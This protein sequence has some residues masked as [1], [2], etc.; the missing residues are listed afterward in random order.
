MPLT[1]TYGDLNAISMLSGSSWDEKNFAQQAV[2]TVSAAAIDMGVSMWNSVANIA[3]FGEYEDVST[4][5]ILQDMGADGALSAYDNNKDAVEL[6]SFVGGVFVPGMAAVKISRGIRAGLKGTNFLSAARHK[7]DLLKFET[8]VKDAQTATDEYRNLRKTMFLRGQAENLMDNVAAE[9]AIL[10]TFNAHP[11]ME[12]YLADPVSNFGISMAIGG[13]LGG[14]IS[15]LITRSELNTLGGKVESAAL[16]TVAKKAQLYNV[17]FSDTSSAII[18]MD[19]AAKNLDNL[20][21]MANTTGLEKEMAM[22]V[23]DSLRNRVTET[24]KAN[25]DID[26]YKIEDA[27]VRDQILANYKDSRM[28]GAER[29]DF[30]VYKA[31]K[32]QTSTAFSK[33]KNAIFKTEEIDIGTG[34]TTQT[35]IKKAF[36]NPELNTF[37]SEKDAL[38]MANAADRTDIKG[39]QALAN[40][41]AVRQQTSAWKDI[42]ISGDAGAAEMD[43]GAKLLFYKGQSTADLLKAEILAEDVS[44]INGYVGAVQERLAALKGEL[45]ELDAADFDDFGKYTKLNAALNNEIM[46]LS[47]AKVKLYSGNRVQLVELE[48][49]QGL[50]T[51]TTDPASYIK[52]TYFEDVTQSIRSGEIRPLVRDDWKGSYGSQLDHAQQLSEGFYT[53]IAT[54]VGRPATRDL[55]NHISPAKL[56]SLTSE[57]VAYPEVKKLLTSMTD[58]DAGLSD[59]TKLLLARWIGGS[60]QDKELFRNA[61]T[62]AR[63]MRRGLDSTTIYHKELTEI[64]NSPV[65]KQA[66]E[67]MKRHA[68]ASGNMYL[69]RGVKGEINGDAPVSSYSHI[70]RSARAFSDSDEVGMYKVNVEDVVGYL[71]S[72]EKEWLVGTGKR[73]MQ[74]VHYAEGGAEHVKK[75]FGNAPAATSGIPKGF[76][77]APTFE[78]L[79][80]DKLTTRLATEQSKNYINAVKAGTPKEIAA[81]QYNIP[82]E[83]MDVMADPNTAMDYLSQA[84]D[85]GLTKF[86]KWAAPSQVPDMLSPTRKQLVFSAT[87]QKHMGIL[88]D[89]ADNHRKAILGQMELKAE[90]KALLNEM[91]NNEASAR[92]EAKVNM[93]DEQFAAI[94]KNWVETAIL[95]SQSQLARSIY[96]SVLNAKDI[97][98]LRESLKE[99]VNGKGGNPLY[100]SA[101]FVTSRMG[102]VGKLVTDISDKR[103]R[104]TNQLFE[105]LAVPIT[106]QLKKLTTNEVA[107][108]EFA[109]FDNLRQSSKDF[110]RYDPDLRTYVTTPKGAKFD[111]TTNQFVVMETDAAGNTV[112]R[113]VAGEPISEL[114][115]ADESVHMAMQRLQDA[116][117]EIYHMQVTSNRVAGMAPPN[118]IGFW[119]P[120]TSLVNKHVGYVVNLDT[121]TIK[122]LIGNTEEELKGLKH[123]YAADKKVN[124]VFY[125]RQDLASAKLQNFDQDTL[126]R[127]TAADVSKQKKGIGLVVPD[128]DPQR[129]SDIIQGIQNRMNYQASKL[130][131]DS[132]FDV[133]SKLDMVS[134]YNR[135]ALDNQGKQGFQSAVKQMANKDTSKDIKA[136]LLGHSQIGGHEAMGYVNKAAS[137]A[138]HYGITA[139]AKAWNLVAP[140]L[141][142]GKVDYKKYV[143]SL[144]AQNIPN[145]YEVF[146]EAARAPM[147]ERA[148]LSIGNLNPDRVINA[149]NA[150]AATMALKFGELAQ[151]LVNM[152]SL[153]ILM[154][155]TISRSVKAAEIET[156][157]Q[158]FEGNPLAVM[159][160]GIRRMN[161][162]SA[163]NLRLKALATEEGMLSPM[164]SEVDDVMKQATFATGGAIGK[165]EKALDSN[166]VKLLSSPSEWAET[167][168]RHAAFF[169]GVETAYRVYGPNLS[170]SQVM[171][172]ARDFMKQ[173]VGNYST[174]QRPMMF[175][176]TAG[177]A[178]GLF[179][180]YMLTY[181]QNMYRH[182]DLK[183]YKGLGK[184]ML[185][186]AGI[187]GAGSMPG[188]QPISNIIGEHFSDENYDITTKLYRALPDEMANVI[189]YGLPSNLAPA[190]HTRGDVNPRIPT[191]VSTMVAP[192]MIA[193]MAQSFIDVGKAIL[194]QDKSTGQAF[195]EALS[196]QSVSRPIARLS[197]L[198]T[199]YSVTRAG[200]QIA[201]NEEVWSWQGVLARVFSTRTLAE[202]KTREAMYKDDYYK[203]VNRENRQAVLETLRSNIRAD[204]ATPQL[205]DKLALEYMRTGSPQGFRQAVNQAFMEHSQDKI[206]SLDRKLG[207]SPLMFMLDDIE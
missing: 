167:Q 179:Q 164:I 180:T 149:A 150:M 172:F 120:S 85:Q 81:M 94:N 186:Q 177:A 119:I 42:I 9:V 65:T 26:I 107:R 152:L 18:H 106:T 55:F 41:H 115:V 136:I 168:V 30:L 200:N 33:L 108:T 17:P 52:P 73:D 197:E 157:G 105:K 63:T 194:D 102:F 45:N 201:G 181:A 11:Y 158:V 49:V 98:I 61:L 6:L 154:T 198:A 31:P 128:A 35:F 67:A 202:A 190:L 48:Q 99:F 141:P 145:P 126:E 148:K 87:P 10:G 95:A 191:G 77:K 69:Y 183:D 56:E 16:D 70:A 117:D 101:D 137:V 15:G 160:A 162:S 147:Y 37:I 20:A 62:S 135:G 165:I 114:K 127:I 59:S 206:I 34:D 133:I 72:A 86:S 138:L 140:T 169:T 130:M 143:D 189:V 131:E 96:S 155:S 76:N 22:S 139:T 113:A 40:K 54:Q 50:P 13:V 173:A 100:S 121:N 28:L 1:T 27:A 57:Y 66:Q 84:L 89:I 156:A 188:F 207:N 93:I 51:G 24:I 124:E 122:M 116:G 187:F 170:D 19:L 14:G 110:L 39:L 125:T 134:H 64:I 97:Q 78:T 185:A 5:S 80:I 103:V 118:D 142:G 29:M 161:S 36:F 123:S 199:G 163:L 176:G 4:R 46:E 21:G 205:L 8:L 2:D 25:T 178:M 203:S 159:M 79:S 44:A 175:Q 3:T 75:I 193:Q 58:E 174:A 53:W 195:F 166:F 68:D 47:N 23:A 92:I 146:A 112:K 192:S 104:A 91:P 32:V 71:Y 129:L 60:Y 144:A 7:D 171:V 109:M 182:L 184:T 204:T 153:P 151:P 12:D 83:L 82:T 132:M 88:G 74:N 111:R 43:Y 196:M 38:R 90:E